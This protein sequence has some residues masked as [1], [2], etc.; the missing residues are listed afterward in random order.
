MVS[1]FRDFLNTSPLFEEFREGAVN[2][3]HLMRRGNAAR[4]FNAQANSSATYD[5]IY[6]YENEDGDETPGN[7]GFAAGPTIP[8]AFPP[9]IQNHVH[10]PTQAPAPQMAHSLPIMPVA[11]TSIGDGPSPPNSHFYAPV[12][13]T[14]SFMTNESANG[15]PPLSAFGHTQAS[16]A[17]G[18]Q[19]P[20]NA[21][22]ASTAHATS[23][24]GASTAQMHQQPAEA[25]VDGVDE[26]L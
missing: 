3:R 19:S 14:S 7:D 24:G 15:A 1:K 2:P 10:N 18:A 26:V 17:G 20:S 8:G 22:A 13:M 4:Q 21:L 12:A 5:D 9:P 16:M 25:Q 6:E 23:A 11:S